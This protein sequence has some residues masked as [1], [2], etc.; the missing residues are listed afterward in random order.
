MTEQIQ[1]ILFTPAT[2]SYLWGGTAQDPHGQNTEGVQEDTARRQ[3]Q[4]QHSSSFLLF[5]CASMI[6]SNVD[7]YCHG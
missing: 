4:I 6:E 7:T 5:R 2:K 1:P 3:K